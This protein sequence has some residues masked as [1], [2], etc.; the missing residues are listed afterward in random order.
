M[1]F[2]TTGTQEPFDR[3][4]KIVDEIAGN[5]SQEKV[6]AQAINDTYKV[7]N[8]EL[9]SFLDPEKFDA[10][11]KK[12]RLV[13]SHAGMGSIIS[14]LTYKKPLVIFPRIAKLGEHRNEHQLATANKFKELGYVH[15]AENEEE[16]V[17]ILEKLL[18]KKELTPLFELGEYAS[19]DLVKSL[20]DFIKQ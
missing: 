12:A 13:I 6:I 2:V 4:L 17:K 19:G 18:Q 3:L 10:V 11:F 8:I 1:I 7:K 5:N 16:L 9:C 20:K 14:A 15:V